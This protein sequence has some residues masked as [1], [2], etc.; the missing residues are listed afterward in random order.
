MKVFVSSVI[1]GF[2]GFRE[3]TARAISSLGYEVV[4]AED[5]G[6]SASSPQQACLGAAREADLMVLLLGARYGAKQASGLSATHEEYQEARKYRPVVAFVQEDVTFEPDQRNFITEVREWET[7]NLTTSFSTEDELRDAV[8]RELHRH[9][10]LAARPIDPQELL[11]RADEA[12][13]TANSLWGAPQ[14]V[15]SLAPG[16]LQEMLRPSEL[17]DPGFARKIQ[18]QALFGPYALFAV[19]ARNQADLRANWLVLSQES[20]SIE[21]SSAGDIVIRRP[22]L[23]V[24]QDLFSVSLPAL[25]E[26]DIEE[27][28]FMA[29]QFTAAMLEHID[30]VHRLSHVG[31]IAA[32]VE[33]T[34]QGWRTRAEHARSPNSMG[35]SEG[36]ER[37]VAV[38]TPSVRAR[39]EIHQRADELAHDLMILLRR[40]FNQ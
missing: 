4:R 16:P 37:V 34:Y 26:E 1:S 38:L 40:E 20:S 8:T 2:E 15:L 7:G 10:V 3:A 28:L 5:F 18:Q 31:I 35:I 21:V 22:A 24:N 32:L 33:V 11:V 29:L 6:A 36:H 9:A 39:A 19:E 17:E 25:I 12:I 30:P 14:L 27:Q 13:G 23:R